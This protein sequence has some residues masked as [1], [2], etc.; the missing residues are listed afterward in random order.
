[1][2]NPRVGKYSEVLGLKHGII[3]VESGVIRISPSNPIPR[4]EKSTRTLPKFKVR[5]TPKEGII[6]G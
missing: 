5:E 3:S 6:E 2:V 4:G 1:V